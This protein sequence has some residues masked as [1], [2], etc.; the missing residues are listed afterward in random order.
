M[1]RQRKGEKYMSD[2]YKINRADYLLLS[3]LYAS[4]CRDYYHSM[5]ISEMIEDNS[6]ENGDPSI[7]HKDDSI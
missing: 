4:G 2:D 1:Q 5:T 7:R 6:D 3:T